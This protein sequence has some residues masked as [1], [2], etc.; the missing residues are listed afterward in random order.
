VSQDFGLKG[1]LHGNRPR[2][3]FH[4]TRP[5][6]CTAR[7]DRSGSNRDLRLLLSSGPLLGDPPTLNAKRRASEVEV[8]AIKP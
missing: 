2:A 8:V 6:L 7:K 4:L 1:P 3:A 5:F